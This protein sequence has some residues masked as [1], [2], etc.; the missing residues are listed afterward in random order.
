MKR[1]FRLT[2]VPQTKPIKKHKAPQVVQRLSGGRLE[3]TDIFANSYTH[4]TD[5]AGETF[6]L[7]S[8]GPAL[9]PLLG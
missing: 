7:D 4:F 5:A 6:W 3:S 9:S 2:N 1:K 8:D